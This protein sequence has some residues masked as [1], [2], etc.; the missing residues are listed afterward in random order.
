MLVFVAAE[1]AINCL[2]LAPRRTD[3]YLAARRANFQTLRSTEFLNMNS[4]WQSPKTSGAIAESLPHARCRQFVAALTTAL[5]AACG[6]IDPAP[7]RSTAP[8]AEVDS[9]RD[10]CPSDVRYASLVS[11]TDVLRTSQEII[12]R[13]LRTIGLNALWSHDRAAPFADTPDDRLRLARLANV[14]LPA[15][16]RY[17]AALFKAIRL[18]NV[19]LVKDLVVAN[20]RRR[21]MPDPANDALVYADNGDALCPAGMELRVHHEL[22]H[23]VDFRQFGEYYFR[24]P[25]W[26]ALNRGTLEYGRGGASVYG[27]GMQ[28]LGHPQAGLVSRYAATGLE[29]DKAETFGWIMTPGYAARVAAWVERDEILAAKWRFTVDS[30]AGKTSG[31]LN[32]LFFTRIA[33]MN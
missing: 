15:L 23:L 5:L 25:A 17:P 10:E 11:P 33:Q 7:A 19:G 2:F 24:D 27:T 1:T 21:A 30:L 18:G 31:A 6:S 28:N 9:L 13:R 16:E 20:Q 14:L 22:F 8:P 29:E 12:T 4:M 32:A 3:V 26:Q